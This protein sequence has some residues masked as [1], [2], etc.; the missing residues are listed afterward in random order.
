MITS[1]FR[2]PESAERPTARSRD[3]VIASTAFQRNLA[4]REGGG[5]LEFVPGKGPA[6]NGALQSF[7][8]H[9]RKQLA[10]G[11]ALQPNLAQQPD[12][13]FHAGLAALQRKGNERGDEVSDEKDDEEQRQLFNAGGVA[14]EGMRMLVNEVPEDAGKKHEVNGGGDDRQEN[15]KDHNVRQSNPAQHA[16]ATEGGAVLPHCLQNSEGPAKALPHKSVG[17]DGRFGKGESAIFIL[18]A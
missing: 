17:V 10:I 14:G 18:H 7:E 16:F 5:A 1:F 13:F 3:R 15:L 4:G 12:I 11:K 6:I 8:Q 9:Q 2:L